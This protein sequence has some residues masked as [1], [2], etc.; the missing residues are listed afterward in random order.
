MDA[1]STDALLQLAWEALP[2]T[3]RELLTHVG[4]PNGRSRQSSSAAQQPACHRRA[5]AHQ[6]A[7]DTA[8]S[9]QALG[10][11]VPNLRLVLINQATPHSES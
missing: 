7:Q 5:S 4:A 8:A 9:N 2:A 10:V 11:W 1:P 6:A 3:H